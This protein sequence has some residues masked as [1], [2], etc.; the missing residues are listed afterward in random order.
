[1]DTKKIQNAYVLSTVVAHYE[2]VSS[3]MEEVHNS[4]LLLKLHKVCTDAV[5]LISPDSACQSCKEA[6]YFAAVAKVTKL[7]LELLH[8]IANI[9]QSV[10]DLVCGSVCGSDRMADTK[11][12]T[13]SYT[14]ALHTSAHA[15]FWEMIVGDVECI[16]YIVNQV[17]AERNMAADEDAKRKM[18]YH[19]M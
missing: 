2:A 12:K 10:L 13:I 16:R 11:E 14:R 6:E 7:L 4:T 1:M 18:L 9:S 17:L 8:A 3:C 19:S 15:A 5:L